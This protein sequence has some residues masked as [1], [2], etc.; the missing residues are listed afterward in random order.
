MRIDGL[1]LPFLK[2]VEDLL[3]L[4]PSA[5]FGGKKFDLPFTI[6]LP[7][8]ASVFEKIARF[9]L[10]LHDEA[11]LMNS[12][13]RFDGIEKDGMKKGDIFLARFYS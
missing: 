12:A 2:G 5:K 9:E 4:F 3:H 11:Q 6:H 1:P 10:I 13:L 7:T 8:E